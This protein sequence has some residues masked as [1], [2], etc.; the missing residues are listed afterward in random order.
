MALLS[1]ISKRNKIGLV[2]KHLKPGDKIL[3]I[4]SKDGWFAEAMRAEGFQVSTMDIVPPADIV[5]DVNQWKELGI[6]EGAYDVSVAFEVIE[7]V[8]CLASLRAVTKPDGII[9]LSSPH[10]KWDW[11]MKIL[12]FLGLNQKRTSP[13]SNLTDFKDISLTPVVFRRPAWI[14]QVAIF[15]NA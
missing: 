7:H 10:P 6:Q 1:E 11:A 5:G 9:V 14:H 2:K 3:E 13:H 4:G 12:E 8:D 15:K